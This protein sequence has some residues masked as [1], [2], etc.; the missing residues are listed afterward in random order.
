MKEY[1]QH[2]G[3]AKG[4]NNVQ[5]IEK[6]NEQQA[7]ASAAAGA[8]FLYRE[9]AKIIERESDYIDMH[10]YDEEQRASDRAAERGW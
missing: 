1:Q 5:Q 2:G 3:N 8:T 7:A 6:T 9:L 10:S 4:A